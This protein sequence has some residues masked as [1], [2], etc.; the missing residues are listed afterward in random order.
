MTSYTKNKL[1][2]GD[3]HSTVR[4]ALYDFT[5]YGNVF[6]TVEFVKDTSYDPLTE[7][8]TVRFVGGKAKRI[9]PYDIVFNPRA[10][11]FE[12]SPKIV[13]YIKTLGDLAL[14]ADTRPELS[15]SEEVVN[16]LYADRNT[17]SGLG[18][19][20][21]NELRKQFTLDG[22]GS[23]DEYYTSGMVELLEFTGNLYNRETKELE[24]NIVVTIVDRKYIV[25]KEKITT[26]K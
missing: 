8:E 21:Q 15:Y 3:F 12:E 14:D 20:T 10:T 1:K 23:I 13:R 6:S 4:Q 19:R 26:W 5:I 2:A 7:E 24:K 11:S 25:R 17:F 18:K 16:Q 22:F 9:S